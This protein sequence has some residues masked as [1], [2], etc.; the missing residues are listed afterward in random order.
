VNDTRKQCSAGH[1]PEVLYER[2]GERKIALAQVWRLAG[3]TL[4]EM[5]PGGHV[6]WEVMAKFRFD[7]VEDDDLLWPNWRD[8]P[9]GRSAAKVDDPIFLQ[10]GEEIAEKLP[11]S[12]PKSRCNG[13]GLVHDS[14]PK[15][16]CSTILPAVDV[17]PGELCADEDR[18]DR[19]VTMAVFSLPA[20]RC[21]PRCCRSTG[22]RGLMR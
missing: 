17:W 14:A 13:L 4:H 1:T 2:V 7:Q 15:L 11:P 12:G 18:P 20:A 5:N 16:H 10:I 3:V 9:G 21:R 19:R 8:K 6:L 22:C